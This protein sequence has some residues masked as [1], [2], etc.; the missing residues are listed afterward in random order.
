MDPSRGEGRKVRPTAFVSVPQLV[1]ELEREL[2]ELAHALLSGIWDALPGYSADYLSRQDFEDLAITHLRLILAVLREQRRPTFEELE[3]AVR[4]GASRALQAVPLPSVLQAYRIAERTLLDAVLRRVDQLHP[5]VVAVAVTLLADI[6]DHLARASVEAYQHAQAEI[7][8]R[9]EHV[10]AGLVHELVAS[11]EV[12]PAD[13]AERAR[14]VG[15]RPDAPYVGLA[16]ALSTAASGATRLR[17]RRQLLADIATVVRGRILAGAW[18]PSSVFVVPCDVEPHDLS[19]VVGRTLARGRP[20]DRAVVGVGEPVERLSLVGRSC[21]EALATVDV[22]GRLNRDSGVLRYSDVIP[23]TL[24]LRDRAASRQMVHARLEGILGNEPLMSTLRT[25]LAMDLSV[26]RTAEALHVH[27][28]TV[29][30][31]LRQ[32]SERTDRDLRRTASIC[33][34]NLALTAADLLAAPA[35]D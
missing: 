26:R 27:Q 11:D 25:Y 24:L 13:V 19:R 35:P 34:L 20:Q 1:D 17:V 33:E 2:E 8:V 18:G 21:R 32:I 4:L 7:T 5:P 30:Y 22:A 3:F 6:I 31:R 10:D 14:L 23:E 28:N 16:A 15:A 29:S 12:D 9:Y